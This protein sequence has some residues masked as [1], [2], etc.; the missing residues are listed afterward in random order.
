MK[1]QT[2]INQFIYNS[3]RV[4]YA[5]AAINAKVIIGS[6]KFYKDAIEVIKY[7]K[8]ANSHN[9]PTIQAYC[10]MMGYSSY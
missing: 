3:K 5:N 9:V 2:E 7:Y 4:I 6:Q 8:N 1:T 10:N